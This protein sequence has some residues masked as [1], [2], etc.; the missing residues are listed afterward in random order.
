[1]GITDGYHAFHAGDIEASFIHY[2]FSAELGFEV[3]Q[4]N[5]AWLLDTGYSS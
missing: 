5:A 4:L 1:M 3:A 2:M